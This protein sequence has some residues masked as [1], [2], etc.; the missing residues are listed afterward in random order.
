MSPLG[1][2]KK[3]W[4]KSLLSSKI[5]QMRRPE[6]ETKNP[7]IQS[8]SLL[9]A[10]FPFDGRGFSLSP[11]ENQERNGLVR[12]THPSPSPDRCCFPQNRTAASRR[13]RRD[14]FAGRPSS[15]PARFCFSHP[16][17]S[18]SKR[19]P[20]ASPAM[21]MSPCRMPRATTQESMETSFTPACTVVSNAAP[22]MP[23]SRL[24][25]TPTIP[26]R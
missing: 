24:T 4:A 20:T 23:P 6:S 22:V 8:T 7:S 19:K 10:G 1:K 5:N 18:P 2:L 9:S 3:V 16:S 15:Q 25:R 12:P 11:S 14:S 21:A 26:R 13:S 17:P